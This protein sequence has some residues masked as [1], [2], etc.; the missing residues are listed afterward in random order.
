MKNIFSKLLA[1][2]CVRAT[3]L[4]AFFILWGCASGAYV[5]PSVSI[6]SSLID[7]FPMTVGIYYSEEFKTYV[8]EDP[9]PKRGQKYV[10]E[11]GSNQE[12][13]FNSTIGG[14]FEK[15]IS[16][17]S[18]DST[19][20]EVDGIFKPEIVSMDLNTPARSGSDYYEV[21]V[22]YNIQLFDPEG[23]ELHKWTIGAYGK[24]NRRDYGSVMERTSDAL[25]QATENA[26]RD[27]ST[28]II[29]NFNP[30]QRPVVVSNWLKPP[31][32]L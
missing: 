11:L 14:L 17:E 18:L 24:V 21:Y 12:Q 26:L 32:Q 27:A 22:R 20:V 4:S 2:W 9:N 25:Q 29:N 7:A 28:L 23:N 30:R 15:V 1:R 16:L 10:I 3:C 6:P 8:Y 19:N 5:V 31:S 13:V